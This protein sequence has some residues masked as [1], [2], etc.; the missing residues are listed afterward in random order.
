VLESAAVMKKGFAIASFAVV[1][2]WTKV[3]KVGMM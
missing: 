1:G 3:E 2:T